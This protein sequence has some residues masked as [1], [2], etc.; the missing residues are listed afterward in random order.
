MRAKYIKTIS[1]LNEFLL[2]QLKEHNALYEGLIQSYSVKDAIR[3]FAKNIKTKNIKN[4]KYSLLNDR[5]N[6]ALPYILISFNGKYSLELGK[7]IISWFKVCGWELTSIFNDKEYTSIEKINDVKNFVFRAK[8]DVEILKKDWPEFLYHLSPKS[9][10][11][12]IFKNGLIPKSENKLLK[13]EDAIYLFSINNE[14]ELEFLAKMLSDKSKK[15]EKEYS[16]FKIDTTR[17]QINFKLFVDPDLENSYFT[18]DNISPNAFSLE[19][20]IN[21]DK[22]KSG[23]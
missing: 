21:L 3:Y 4:V 15:Q 2:N 17:L 23:I 13:H 1:D 16:L 14:L 20:N 19:R 11:D 10:Q 7:E 12:K 5:E 6:G 8:F 9:K 22:N 18:K